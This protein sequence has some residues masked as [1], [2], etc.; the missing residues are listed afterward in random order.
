MLKKISSGNTLKK[1]IPVTVCIPTISTRSD[2]LVRALLSIHTQTV[3]PNNIIVSY[4]SDLCAHRVGA[5]G[6]RNNAL[7]QVETEYVAFIDDDD[8]MYPHHLE[9][10]YNKIVETKVDLVYP[11][12]VIRHGGGYIIPRKDYYREDMTFN[13]DELMKQNYIPITVMAK[14]KVLQDLGGFEN[15]DGVVGED[16]G[17]WM[18]LHRSGHTLLHVPVETW[19]YNWWGHGSP[20]NPGNTSGLPT[21]W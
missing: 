17:M 14:T 19:E 13:Y 1:V 3:I 16:W 6:N 10:L 5:T 8:I 18:K 15:I 2:K 4:D 21:R 7:N 11:T 20:G 12:F 9:T